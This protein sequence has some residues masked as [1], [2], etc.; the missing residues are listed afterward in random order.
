MGCAYSMSCSGMQ[1]CGSWSLPW[2]Q[3]WRGSWRPSQGLGIVSVDQEDR[4]SGLSGDGS[5]HFPKGPH[6]GGLAHLKI[7]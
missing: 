1:A 5:N 2:A 7:Y 4:A 6:L 3:G